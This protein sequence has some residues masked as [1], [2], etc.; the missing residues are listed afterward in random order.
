MK[1]RYEE[2]REIPLEGGI[3]ITTG[4]RR[5]TIRSLEANSQA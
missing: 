5:R 1:K 4:L 3:E 2:K